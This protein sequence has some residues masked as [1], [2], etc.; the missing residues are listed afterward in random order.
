M[1]YVRPIQ[2]IKEVIN[3]SPLLSENLRLLSCVL[4]DCQGIGL[5]KQAPEDTVR[6]FVEKQRDFMLVTQ[7]VKDTTG[8]KMHGKR[9]VKDLSIPPRVLFRN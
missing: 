3:Q 6:S 9:S 2:F 8:E 5:R 7:M 1:L 4:Y